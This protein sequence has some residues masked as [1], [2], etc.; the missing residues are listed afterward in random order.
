MFLSPSLVVSALEKASALQS[1]AA[2]YFNP[3]HVSFIAILA[4]TSGISTLCITV[5]VLQPS[6]LRPHT[7]QL[8]RS[9]IF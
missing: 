3:L 4:V 8:S 9:P 2:D 6:E 5:V 7:L 1:S